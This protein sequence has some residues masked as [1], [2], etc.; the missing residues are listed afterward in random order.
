MQRVLICGATGNIG[1]ELIRILEKEKIALTAGYNKSPTVK[2]K[3]N[4]VYIDFQYPES[5]KKAFYNCDLMFLLIPNDERM[6]EFAKNAVDI[7]RQLSVKFIVHSSCAGA[8]SNSAYKMVRYQGTIDDYIRESGIPYAITRPQSFMQNFLH[9]YAHDIRQGE[10]YSATGRGGVSWIDVRDIAAVNAKIIL[11]PQK[12]EGCELELTGSE[13]LSFKEAVNKIADEIGRSVR[14]N[15]ISTEDARKGMRLA[16][17]SKFN[18]DMLSSINEV[19]RAGL[20]AGVSY[21][22]ENVLQKKPISFT[23]FTKDY[24]EAWM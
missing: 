5:L 12:Y 6:I 2:T 15:E 22:V 17:L 21:A 23:Q 20:S 10:T 7:A 8:N 18:I 9:F 24:R 4:S 1:S 14:V 16:G 13:I 3:V 19:T 11:N